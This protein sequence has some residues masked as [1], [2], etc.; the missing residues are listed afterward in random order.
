MAV[1]FEN[2]LNRMIE[3]DYKGIKDQSHLI[4]TLDPKQRRVLELFEKFEILTAGQ[5]GELFGFKSR[6]SAKLCQN[7][8]KDGFLE[9]FDFSNKGR[10]YKL[11]KK[12]EE[13]ISKS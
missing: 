3:A 7:W 13:L 10:K 6:T 9:I 5:I 1:S 4:R 11:S 12:Y 2:V 8:V